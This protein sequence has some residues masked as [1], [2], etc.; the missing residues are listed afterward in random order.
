MT[1]LSNNISQKIQNLEK[2]NP[3]K[4]KALTEPTLGLAQ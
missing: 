1:T 2:E 4:D 3:V